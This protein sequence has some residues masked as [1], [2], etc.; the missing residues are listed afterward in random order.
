MPIYRLLT[1]A[2]LALASCAFAQN[3]TVRLVSW[4][5][6][7]CD[8]SYDPYS[9]IDRIS[10]L[11]KE[12]NRTYL[13]ISFTD[14]C[15]PTFNPAISLQEGIAFIDPYGEST[16]EVR[17]VCFCTCCFAL[18]LTVEGLPEEYQTYFRE[19]KIRRSDQPYPAASQNDVYMGQPINREIV[20]E[21]GLDIP[22]K[23]GLWMSFYENGIVETMEHYDST[24]LDYNHNHNPEW[25]K[26][27]YPSGNL[28]SFTR[29][30]TTETWFEDGEP[31]SQKITYTAGKT[32][33][34]KYSDKHSNRSL[35]AR[36]LIGYNDELYVAKP[37]YDE[38]YFS[39]G[40]LE[41]LYQNDTT[42]KWYSPGH[43]EF[44]QY[45][46][47]KIIYTRD[48][49]VAWRQYSWQTKGPKYIRKLKHV[50]TV[51]FDADGKA[52]NIQ[53]N[54]D[55]Y[56][57][58]KGLDSYEYTW[59]WNDNSTLIQSPMQWKGAKPWKQ[60]KAIRTP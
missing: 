56:S 42:F 18:E 52:K 48:G 24:S 3:N 16:D 44:K 31:K 30:D 8:D 60:F 57:K 15:C 26:T 58:D 27:F 36:S 49:K 25:I 1:F 37:T 19:R 43:L 55:E 34:T 17:E 6:I 59:A 7:P 33:F 13:T 35:A 20:R 47:G 12:G 21:S 28:Y 54:R 32:T 4:T 50:M 51:T 40:E 5:H 46:N 22:F 23:V 14:Q 53:Y 41:R 9:A 39:T 2:F 29:K 10:A 11:R 45:S 38:K